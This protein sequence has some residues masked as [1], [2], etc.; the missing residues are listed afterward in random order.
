M[1]S[2]STRK[3]TVSSRTTFDRVAVGCDFCDVTTKGVGNRGV[4]GVRECQKGRCWFKY[5]PWRKSG[6]Y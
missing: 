3:T 1:L 2:V 4:V 5:N 6:V